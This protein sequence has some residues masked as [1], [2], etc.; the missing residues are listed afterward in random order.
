MRKLFQDVIDHLQ[1]LEMDAKEKAAEHRKAYL[2]TDYSAETLAPHVMEYGEACNAAGRQ[3]AYA[4]ARQ[5]VEKLKYDDAARFS[6]TILSIFT[7]Q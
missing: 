5:M 3:I 7:E 4:N 6:G 1:R 2:P